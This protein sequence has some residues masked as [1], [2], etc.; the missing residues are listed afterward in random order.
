MLDQ[1]NQFDQFQPPQGAPE[2]FTQADQLSL[3][4]LQNNLSE[5]QKQQDDNELIPQHADELRSQLLPRIQSLTQRQQATQKQ[6]QQQAQQATMQAN[7]AAQAM[8]QHDSE[9]RAQGLPKRVVPYTDPVSGK[10][11]HLYESAPNKWEEIKFEHDSQ[12]QDA[13]QN[14]FAEAMGLHQKATPQQ[15]AEA[16]WDSVAEDPA[17][18]EM[19][20]V[21]PSQIHQDEKTGQ[22]Y[23]VEPDPRGGLPRVRLINAQRHDPTYTPHELRQGFPGQPGQPLTPGSQGG[24]GGGIP[25]DI[26]VHSIGLPASGVDDQTASPAGFEQPAQPG[27]TSLAQLGESMRQGSLKSDYSGAPLP[28]ILNAAGEDITQQQQE[29]YD[30]FKR[31]GSWAPEPTGSQRGQISQQLLQEFVRRAEASVPQVDPNNHHAVI[32]R[33]EAVQRLVHAQTSRFE[34]AQEHAAREQAATTEHTRSEASRSTEASR[35]EEVMHKHK[36]DEAKL[37][38]EQ[39]EQEQQQLKAATKLK[40]SFDVTHQAHQKI[41]QWRKDPSN[42]DVPHPWEKDPDAMEKWIDDQVARHMKRAGLSDKKELG[43]EV[44]A[45][46]PQIKLVP[47]PGNDYGTGK[48]LLPPDKRHLSNVLD[49]ITTPDDLKRVRPQL[50]EQMQSIKDQL[51]GLAPA[52]G[53]PQGQDWRRD[54]RKRELIE[55]SLPLDQMLSTVMAA[56][57]DK[58]RHLTIGERA[59]YE[60]NLDKLAEALK[61]AGVDPAQINALRLRQKES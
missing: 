5:I 27:V 29:Q 44:K 51:A 32:A 47:N 26:D 38:K 40:L 33:Q 43:Q 54:K 17:T 3:Q 53:T 25:T 6:A 22:T 42:M 60:A 24:E 52:P 46:P 31:T 34:S 56:Q 9:F 20:E 55:A 57:N 23:L 2:P 48:D 15:A 39:R 10:T 12:N 14:Q 61:K 7:A 49:P 16:K 13:E 45:P 37:R 28:R 8:S 30:R 36:E 11:A 4:R 19:I 58:G 41:E 35:H 21:D 59:H 50:E 18:G 1:Q